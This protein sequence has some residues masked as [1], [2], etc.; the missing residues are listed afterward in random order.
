MAF[1]GIVVSFLTGR[2]ISRPVVAMS[3][4]MRELA[5][6]NFDVR[7]PGLDRRDEVGQMAH[8]VQEFKVQAVAKAER[9]TAEREEKNLA[10]AAARR[11]ELQELAENFETTV[12]NIIENVGTASDELESSAVVLSKSSAATQ[13]LSTV[14][15]TASEETSANVQSVAS[16]TEEMASSINEIGR[17]VVEFQPDRQ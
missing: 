16:A 3:G 17:Q 9:D 7:L 15:A 5:A 11:A 6:G 2:S 13:Q 1:A 4:A 12:G 10:T 14:V 8:A